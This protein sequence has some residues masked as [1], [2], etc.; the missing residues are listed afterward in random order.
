MLTRGRT[1][2]LMAAL[3][4]PDVIGPWSAMGA[5]PEAVG[6]GGGGAGA[7]AVLESAAGR[8]G[9]DEDAPSAA[10]WPAWR[11]TVR[12]ILSALAV[13]APAVA[14]MRALAPRAAEGDGAGAA[15]APPSPP[16]AALAPGVPLQDGGSPA[17]GAGGAPHDAG[18]AATWAREGSP[19]VA[20]PPTP[21]KL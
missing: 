21:S 4:Q 2:E 14:I 10:R 9:A 13:A 12:Q 17:V 6:S 11:P 16:G 20:A 15:A 3:D 1:Q 19:L 5:P 8:G 7:T 18:H